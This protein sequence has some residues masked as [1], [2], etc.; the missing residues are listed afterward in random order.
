[1]IKFK[2][3]TQRGHWMVLGDGTYMCYHC[4]GPLAGTEFVRV[5]ETCDTLVHYACYTRVMYPPMPARRQAC[6][7]PYLTSHDLVWD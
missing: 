7:T 3:L 4:S 5:C 1:M 2:R 6:A